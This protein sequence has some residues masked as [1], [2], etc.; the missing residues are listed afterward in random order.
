MDTK[1]LPLKVNYVHQRCMCLTK[2][3]QVQQFTR[4]LGYTMKVCK[5]KKVVNEESNNKFI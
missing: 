1:K 4:V 2:A 3:L 5:K